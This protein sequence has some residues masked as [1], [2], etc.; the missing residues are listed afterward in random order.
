[1]GLGGVPLGIMVI[2]LHNWDTI[3]ELIESEANAGHIYL[4][5]VSG[6]GMPDKIGV[7]YRGKN[8][9]RDSD[10]LSFLVS[11]NIRE[12]AT[13]IPKTLKMDVERLVRDHIR[14]CC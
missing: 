1:M 8:I 14:P 3:R 4:V 12:T 5:Q 9:L 6:C 7:R 2:D 10:D 13:R 11:G